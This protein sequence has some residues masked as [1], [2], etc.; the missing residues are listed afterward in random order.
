[1]LQPEAELLTGQ[2][3]LLHLK[4]VDTNIFVFFCLDSWN[5][6]QVEI[7]DKMLMNAYDW[8]TVQRTFNSTKGERSR[9]EAVVSKRKV[10]QM[11]LL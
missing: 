6:M 11:K 8:G 7:H 4:F 5:I 9:K 1:M 10:K 3:K 2:D